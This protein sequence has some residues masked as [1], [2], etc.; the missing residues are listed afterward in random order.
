MNSISNTNIDYILELT[1]PY[2]LRE[3]FK[4]DHNLIKFISKSRI[5]IGDILTG[6]DKRL[7]C[8]VG[9]CSIHDFKQAL[10]YAIILNRLHL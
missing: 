9:P 4:L 7:L 1:K 5:T 3:Q 2:I 6:E 10:D 8:I